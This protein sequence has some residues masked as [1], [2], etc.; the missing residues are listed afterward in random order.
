MPLR[1]EYKMLLFLTIVYNIDTNS[2][3]YI[4][5]PCPLRNVKSCFYVTELE[6]EMK[7]GL[8]VNDTG[9]KTFKYSVLDELKQL[10]LTHPVKKYDIFIVKKLMILYL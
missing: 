2:V 1:S 3:L 8:T 7:Y 6:F 4:L 5:L 10:N 9:E